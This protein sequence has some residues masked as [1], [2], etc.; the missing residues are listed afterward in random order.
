MT[1]TASGIEPGQRRLNNVQ[2]AGRAYRNVTEPSFEVDRTNDVGI[3]TRD[4]TTL[5]A[6]V[7]RPNTAATFPALVSFSCYSRQIQDLGAPVGFIEAG[8]TDFFVPRGYVHVIANCRGT[9]GSGGTF[10]FF[11]SQERHDMHDLVEWAAQRPWSDGN[12]GMIG[13]SY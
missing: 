9:S 4:G 13:I 2:T 3:E 10:G 11:D 6:D 8:A 12:I 7:Y 5:L 1:V